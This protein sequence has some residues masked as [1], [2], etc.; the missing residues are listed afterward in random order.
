MG[1]AGHG[2]VTE[3]LLAWSGGETTALD[4]VM[5]PVYAELHRL[6]RRYM[7][8][9]KRRL[10]PGRP[11]VFAPKWQMF[12]ALA[13]VGLLRKR[14][15]AQ[16]FALHAKTVQLQTAHQRTREALQKACEAESLDLDG[17]RILELI[18]RDEAVHL[19]VDN[20]AE[21]VVVHCEGAVSAILLEAPGGPR[22][23]AVPA[24]PADW[25]EVLGQ[26]EVRLVSFT[27]GF[28]APKQFSDDPAWAAFIDSQ[29]CARFRT[30][31]AAP[32]TVDSAPCDRRILQE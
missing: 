18:A 9:D 28:R 27:P 22:V 17:K 21:A 26:I 30:F 31:C 2:E 4:K 8:R 7:S 16:T 14:V 5:P 23:C 11:H 10:G 1:E 6:A 19:I 3:L 20:I 15:Q 13:W 32:I 12:T 29:N 24:L 25:M